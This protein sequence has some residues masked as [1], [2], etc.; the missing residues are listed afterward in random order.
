MS[1]VR[2]QE[3]T[4]APT[5]GGEVTISALAADLEGSEMTFVATSKG[6]VD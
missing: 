5:A 3:I 4:G 1:A 2:R 6:L